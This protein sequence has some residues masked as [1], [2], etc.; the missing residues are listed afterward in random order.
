M[1]TREQIKAI[2]DLKVETVLVPEWGGEV[3][4]RGFTGL[5][6]DAFEQKCLEQGSGT[7][8]QNIKGLK[9]RMVMETVCTEDGTALLFKEEDRGWLAE[10]S[11]AAIDR[12]F[13]VAKR[14]SGM[15]D[16]EVEKLAENSSAGRKDASGSD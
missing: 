9:L 11:A 10:K 14:L 16:E 7:A 6:R 2:Q 15:G 12:I 5:E 13:Q 3:S 4:V 1:L 8:K